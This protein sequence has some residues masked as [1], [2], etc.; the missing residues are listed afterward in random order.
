[1]KIS[2]QNYINPNNSY[3]EVPVKNPNGKPDLWYMVISKLTLKELQKLKKR[4]QSCSTNE[5]MDLSKTLDKV[6]KQTE[7]AW[8]RSLRQQKNRE[9]RNQRKVKQRIRGKEGSLPEIRK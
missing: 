1:M 9:L 8:Y 5:A 3:I 4:V 2:K 6:I 7:A